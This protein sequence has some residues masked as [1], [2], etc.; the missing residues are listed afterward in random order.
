M[1]SPTSPAATDTLSYEQAGVNYDLID[2]LKVAA[3]RAAAAT[4][5]HLGAHGFSEIAASRGES[6]YVVDVG[7]FYLASIVECL[8]SKA[9]VADEM[10]RLTGKSYYE[11]IAQDTI[12]MAINDLITVGATPLVVQAYWAAG[13]SDWF[14]DATR[15]QAL[16]AGW[17][18]ACD[19]CGVAWGGGETPAL[20][21]IVEAGRI[22][23]AASC[24][25]LINPKERL[26][27][28]DRLGAG[29]AI[30]LLASSGIHANGLSLARKLAERLPQGYLTELSPGLSFGEALLAPT[31][32]YSPVTE[33]LYRAGITPHY[34]ANI[35]GHGWRKLL[36]HPAELTYRITQVPEVTPV[37]KFIQQ[38]AKQDDREAYSTLNMGA[39]FA[40]FVPADQ[41]ERTV[42]VAKAQ[43]VHALVAGRVEAGAKQLIIEPL[44][45]TFGNEDLQ[46]R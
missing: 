34:C 23:L 26:S 8:G 35:T 7:P 32:L 22:D 37:L 13:G 24:T 18:K 1:S 36:R 20:A 30:V 9:L 40:I 15:A 28:G 41:A 29:D 4:G 45:I 38:H 3:Q 25:G 16:V 2:P 17:K 19:I 10:A 31:V 27:V 39:G 5:A 44:S 33:A 6:A 42:E 11:G 21:G 12:A 14:G 46:L 43:G